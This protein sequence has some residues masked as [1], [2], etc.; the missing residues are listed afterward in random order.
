VST[1]YAICWNVKKEIANG[2]SMLVNLIFVSK[3]IFILS[4]KKLEYLKN[5]K[6]NILNAIPVIKKKFL[7]E[8]IKIHKPKEKLM[9]IDIIIT[10]I[11]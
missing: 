5:P 7:L 8:Y 10:K 6:Y 2:S 9:I 4:I 1:R 3:T 11:L